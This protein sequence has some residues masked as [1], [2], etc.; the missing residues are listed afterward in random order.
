MKKIKEKW[1]I[2]MLTTF[3]LELIV[4]IWF[5]FDSE[6]RFIPFMVTLSIALVVCI[7]CGYKAHRQYDLD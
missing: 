1:L 3:V 2:A 7:F 6:Q 5:L 4:Y